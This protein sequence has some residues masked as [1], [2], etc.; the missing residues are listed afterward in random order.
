MCNP[1]FI[2]LIV[3]K[4]VGSDNW[5]YVHQ[6]Y[7]LQLNYNTVLKGDVSETFINKQKFYDLHKNGSVTGRKILR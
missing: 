4:S 5:T 6:N 7:T 3:P 1:A 2:P